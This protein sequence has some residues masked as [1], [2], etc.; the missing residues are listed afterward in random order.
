MLVV[1]GDTQS[2]NIVRILR[3]S[4]R[5]E[6]VTFVQKLSGCTSLCTLSIWLA[7]N[8]FAAINACPQLQ[9]L[10]RLTLTS[11]LL[12]WIRRG[13][14][15]ILHL[16]MLEELRLI[17]V[18]PDGEKLAPMFEDDMAEIIRFTVRP[19]SVVTFFFT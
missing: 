7:E 17:N 5:C 9:S 19:F 4:L 13:R 16:E 18:Q 10:T 2:I 6:T 8:P 15:E 12:E 1:L 11:E 3:I 14:G